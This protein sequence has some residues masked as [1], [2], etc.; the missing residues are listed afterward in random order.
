MFGSVLVF[1]RRHALGLLVLVL[2]AGGCSYAA[3]SPSSPLAMRV[4]V[5]TATGE[6]HMPDAD[7][8]CPS[9]ERSFVLGASGLPG[10]RGFRGQRG[11]PGKKGPRG[12]AGVAGTKGATGP[13]GMQGPTGPAGIQG[14]MG[15]AG[16]AG[17][18][19]TTGPTG[20][21]GTTGSTGATGAAG[22]GQ[23]AEFFA[24]MPPD[25]AATVAPGTA[26]SFP[27]AGPNSGVISRL[28]ASTFLLPNVGTYD[29]DFSVSV[30]EAGQLDLALNG[31]ELPYTVSGR[32][33]GTSE[34][35]GNALV[36]TNTVDS[37]LSVDNPTGNP[38]ALTITP[39]AG[40][41]HPVA[42]SLVIEQLN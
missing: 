38:T 39:L 35:T 14:A 24:L 41:T 23:D 13:A 3:A 22:L 2:V 33:T 36:T 37:I 32:A 26:V 10:P 1:A 8:Q 20:P 31:S 40:G 11:R 9:G 25:N 16:A 34:I 30:T 6:L 7:G 18:P 17:Q 5:E 15:Q 19:G 12:L 42:A 27:Q 29:V 4:C 21:T 28:S